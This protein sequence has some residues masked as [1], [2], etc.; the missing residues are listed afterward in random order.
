VNEYDLQIQHNEALELAVAHLG[1]DRTK[2]DPFFHGTLGAELMYVV[3]FTHPCTVVDLEAVRAEIERRGDEARNAVI[4]ALGAEIACGPWLGDYNKH[5]PINKLRLIDL[6]TD[7][8]YGKFFEHQ[9][10][11]AQIAFAE[12]DGLVQVQIKDFVSPSILE[13]LGAEDGIV[14]PI[15]DDW[16]AMVDSIFV[17]AAFDGT[18]FSIS[19]ADIPARQ[20][21]LVKGSYAVRRGH[22]DRPIAVRITDMLGEELIA[23][24][25]TRAA[26]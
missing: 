14:A 2:A 25:P 16:R 1:A 21:D 12:Q 11:R 20:D 22:P 10:S 15:I 24:E 9:P 5:R 4:V 19:L 23:V 26:R 6:R 17:D 18:T 13:R 7:A 8:K 3:S